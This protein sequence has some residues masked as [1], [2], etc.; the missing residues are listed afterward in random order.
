ML[1]ASMNNSGT[2]LVTMYGSDENF[3]NIQQFEVEVNLR[4]HS[5]PFDSERETDLSAFKN[6]SDFITPNCAL[7]YFKLPTAC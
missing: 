3:P 5:F 1:E 4:S 2:H 7:Y 6:N